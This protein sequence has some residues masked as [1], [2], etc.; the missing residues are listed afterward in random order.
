MLV[1]E[2]RT[3]ALNMIF[4]KK[5]HKIS[6]SQKEEEVAVK[7]IGFYCAIIFLTLVFLGGVASYGLA[8]F[9]NFRNK[10]RQSEAKLSLSSIYELGRDFSLD[11]SRY[12]SCLSHFI[13]RKESET[14]RKYY[15]GFKP[16]SSKSTECAAGSSILKANDQLSDFDYLPYFEKSSATADS[17]TAIAAGR[18]CEDCPIDVWSINEKKELVNIQSGLKTNYSWIVPVASLF[19]IIALVRQRKKMK[20]KDLKIKLPNNLH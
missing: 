4:K 20:R 7:S 1:V 19:L 3:A 10:A 14:H 11:K 15:V 16:D 18:L 12:T 5:H 6:K 8:S 17:F 9:A 13:A 2:F